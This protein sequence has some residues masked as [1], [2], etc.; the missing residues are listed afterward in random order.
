MIEI[1]ATV[2]A[3]SCDKSNVTKVNILELG[4]FR[5]ETLSKSCISRYFT[6]PKEY[7]RSY[8]YVIGFEKSSL[9]RTQEQDTLFT[10]KR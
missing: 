2:K 9:P 5:K 8:V 6:F 4:S 1:Q 3:H 10:I 7:M